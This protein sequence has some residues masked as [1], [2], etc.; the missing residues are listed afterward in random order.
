M[1]A[2]SPFKRHHADPAQ[3]REVD[4]KRKRSS[5]AVAPRAHTK[6]RKMLVRKIQK[7]AG[8][9][10]TIQEAPIAGQVWIT[11][12]IVDPLHMYIST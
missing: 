10:S 6:A 11:P 1:Q 8:P 2:A 9:S 7:E 3:H 4:P 5:D 12:L